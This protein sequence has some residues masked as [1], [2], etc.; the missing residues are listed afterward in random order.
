MGTEI[1]SKRQKLRA[2]RQ[3]LRAM[4]QELRET[5]SEADSAR[6]WAEKMKRK[7][8]VQL[9]IFQLKR[10]IIAAKEG[11]AKNEPE[12]GALPDFVVIG[13]AKSGTSFFYHLLSQH[14]LVEPAAFKELQFFDVH[15]GEGVE[16]YR[17]GLPQPSLKGGRRTIT[18]EATPHYLFHPHAAQRMAQ[19]VPKARLIALLRNPVDRAYSHYQ[20]VVKNGRETLYFEEAIRAEGARLRCERDKMLRDEHYFSTDYRAFS[21]LSTGVYVDQLLRGRSSLA[22]SRCSC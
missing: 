14:P 10:A 17:R 21:Y 19:V 16:W 1:E 2:M 13:A 4:R 8:G 5:R 12:T 3:E 15:F 11:R 9:E 20:M 6:D 7:K 18:G 22:K